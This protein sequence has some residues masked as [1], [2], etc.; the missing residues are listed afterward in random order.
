MQKLR[1]IDLATFAFSVARTGRWLFS[2][3]FQWGCSSTKTVDF[4]IGARLVTGIFDSWRVDVAFGLGAVSFMKE[5]MT[6]PDRDDMTGVSFSL[7]PK[8][9]NPEEGLVYHISRSWRWRK[10]SIV[11]SFREQYELFKC[12]LCRDKIVRIHSDGSSEVI[13][14][15]ATKKQ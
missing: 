5:W 11:P 9:W 1:P 4:D 7:I 15:L 12:G 2:F 8:S 3:H 13:G 10:M 14:V 6:P